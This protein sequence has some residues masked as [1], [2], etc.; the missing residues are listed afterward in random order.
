MYIDK[1]YFQME[2]Q[3][4]LDGAT[5]IWKEQRLKKQITNLNKRQANLLLL[6]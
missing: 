1:N 4:F 2:Q 3:T 6:I 5:W